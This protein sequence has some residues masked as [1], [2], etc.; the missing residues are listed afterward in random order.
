MAHITV[1]ICMHYRPDMQ[2]KMKY[3]QYTGKS[4]G[5]SML[6]TEPYGWEGGGGGG[7]MV[8]L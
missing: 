2:L 3:V 7:V 6:K 4:Y 5:V 1:T 8:G